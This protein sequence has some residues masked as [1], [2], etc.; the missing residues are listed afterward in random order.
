MLELTLP[1]MTCGDCVNGVTKAIK[2][3]TRRLAVSSICAAI[4]CGP[5][6]LQA[7]RPSSLR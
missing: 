5:R 4:G 3:L 2:Q 1:T 7:A 6:P